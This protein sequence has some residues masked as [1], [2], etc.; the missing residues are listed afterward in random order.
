MGLSERIDRNIDLSYF[1][2][3]IPVNYKYTYGLGLEKFFRSIKDKGEFLACRCPVC[4]AVYFPCRVFCERCFSEISRTF[5]VS[6]K[7][8]VYS[9]TVSHLKIDGTPKK[10]P[11]VI[12]LIEIDG[13]EGAKIVHR[14]DAK[15][16]AVEIGMKVSPVLKTKKD[17]RGDL[18]DIKA[19]KRA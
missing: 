16:R 9:Y 12:G 10:E 1:E 19:F 4:G 11:E 15:P 3:K 2:G 17:R 8:T 13:T 5:K 6:G 18:F 7:G 14:L